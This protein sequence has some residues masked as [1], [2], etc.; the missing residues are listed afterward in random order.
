MKKMAAL[1]IATFQPNF[2]IN[3]LQNDIFWRSFISYIYTSS[4]TLN[5]ACGNTKQSNEFLLPDIGDLISILCSLKKSSSGST[6]SAQKSNL[7]WHI[8]SGIYISAYPPHNF[9]NVTE[10]E[11]SI[12]SSSYPWINKTGQKTLG[13]KSI[14]LNWSAITNYAKYPHLSY[15]K[16]LIDLKADT[17]SRQQGYL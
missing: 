3:Q 2:F 17:S 4:G 14:F 15:T 16:L 10:C 5:K 12:S 1:I 6:K 8:L 9:I 11:A 7:L 13:I